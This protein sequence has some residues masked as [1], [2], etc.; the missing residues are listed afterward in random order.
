MLREYNLGDKRKKMVLYSFY[1]EDIDRV[2]VIGTGKIKMQ[3]EREKLL[4]KGQKPSSLVEIS[5]GIFKVCTSI[6]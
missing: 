4:K 5:K 1:Y 2:Y 3:K 6:K